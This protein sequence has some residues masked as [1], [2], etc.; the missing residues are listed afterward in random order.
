M[1]LHVYMMW[2]YHLVPNNLIYICITQYLNTNKLYLPPRSPAFS[3]GRIS[4][5]PQVRQVE[6][7]KN[8]KPPRWWICLG[9]IGYE[10]QNVSSEFIV[11]YDDDDDD[12][13]DFFWIWCDWIHMD[14]QSPLV[15]SSKVIAWQK[16]TPVW[17]SGPTV[18]PVAKRTFLW[19]SYSKCSSGTCWKNPSQ[20]YSIV[21][22]YAYLPPCIT[23]SCKNMFLGNPIVRALDIS[24]K[25]LMSKLGRSDRGL[26]GSLGIS[27]RDPSAWGTALW[28]TSC[29][30]PVFSIFARTIAQV[31]STKEAFETSEVSALQ[32]GQITPSRKIRCV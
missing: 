7:N 14:E 12:D 8:L 23:M 10:W 1:L 25:Q 11:Y 31:T 17:K 22:K 27:T 30:R 26:T 16:G 3:P 18:L 15:K 4:S 13:D 6:V 21:V 28:W 20:V 29:G 19:A 5:K 24:A 2:L 32:A 9:L